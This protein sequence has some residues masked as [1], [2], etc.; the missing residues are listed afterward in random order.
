MLYPDVALFSKVDSMMN[1]RLTM[2]A[3]AFNIYGINLTG[4]KIINEDV[5]IPQ[6]G[7]FTLFID[8]YWG[9]LV[10]RYGVISTVLVGVISMYT[11]YSMDKQDRRIELLLVS[12]ICVFGLSEST[13]LDIY[14]VFPWLFLKETAAYKYLEN[15]P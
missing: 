10:I 12:M 5:F 7:Y 2:V 1:G 15:R 9:M 11:A 4:H 8:N 13:A 14:P 3:G 6:L